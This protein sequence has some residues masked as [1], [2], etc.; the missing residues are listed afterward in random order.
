MPQV[1]RFDQAASTWDLEGMRVALA[2]GVAGAIAA[3]VPLSKDLT[4]LDF[5]CGTGLVSLELAAQVG[6]LTGAD[7][8][9]GMLKALAEKTAAAGIAMTLRALDPAGPLDLGGPYDLIV[10][11]MTS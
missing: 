4:L 3:R 9:P 5:G 7:S 2:Q 1:N 6:P 11:S 10:S 8:S